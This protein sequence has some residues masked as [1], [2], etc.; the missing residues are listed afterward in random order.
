MPDSI[1]PQTYPQPKFR[2]PAGYCDILL[3]RHGTSEPADPDR[4]FPMAD[5]L[6]DPALAPEGEAQAR[7]VAERLGALPLAAIYVTTLRRTHQSAAPLAGATGLTPVGE[8]RLREVFL[9]EWD[10]G[11][12]RKMAAEGHPL[13]RK[14]VETGDWGHIPGAETSAALQ[15]RVSAGLAAIAARHPD[16]LVAVFAHGGSIG[17]ALEHATGARP[18]SFNG[19]ANGAISRLVMRGD[20]RILRGY[21]DCAHLP[22]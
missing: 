16:R 12:Y 6:G 7:A 9:G 14:A 8:P 11:L 4:P 20:H 22:D 1:P 10:G 18:F 17:A 3:I 15:A 2:V 5:G 13:Y 21:N 19:S